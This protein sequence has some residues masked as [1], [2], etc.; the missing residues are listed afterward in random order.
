[1]AT[2][3]SVLYGTWNLY[4]QVEE[5]GS[6]YD[7]YEI[8]EWTD[9]VFP[10]HVWLWGDRMEEIDTRTYDYEEYPSE[11]KG[12]EGAAVL[13]A[14]HAAYEIDEELTNL[15]L[16]GIDGLNVNVYDSVYN[17]A[18]WDVQEIEEII[19]LQTGDSVDPWAE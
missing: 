17:D 19:D 9:K 12:F 14:N 3:I 7:K 16:V 6:F 2:S 10:I 18:D 1:M 11:W 13:E 15:D 8:E 5:T 4:K